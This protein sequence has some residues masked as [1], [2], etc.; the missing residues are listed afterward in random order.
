QF[1]A[2]LSIDLESMDVERG[3]I[4][5]SLVISHVKVW[6][7]AGGP[8]LENVAAWA[9]NKF[10]ESVLAD[11]GRAF[12]DKLLRR[13]PPQKSQSVPATITKPITSGIRDY[14]EV[15]QTKA[16]EV[17][18]AHDC[19]ARPILAGIAVRKNNRTVGYLYAYG[20]RGVTP[21]RHPNYLYVTVYCNTHRPA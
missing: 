12:A 13:L 8:A 2:Q 15:A 11:F 14:S 19:E 6:L 7:R 5:I 4:D 17:A 21:T 16:T 1:A 9:G 10:A 20:L 3:S 18:K